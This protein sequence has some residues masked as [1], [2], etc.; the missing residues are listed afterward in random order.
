MKAEIKR[1]LGQFEDAEAIIR[2]FQF[3]HPAAISA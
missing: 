2:H 1:E 3:N